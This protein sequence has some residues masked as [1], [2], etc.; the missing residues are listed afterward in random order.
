MHSTP[1]HNLTNKKVSAIAYPIIELLVL[2]AVVEVKH[3]TTLRI[4]AKQGL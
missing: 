4:E 1:N 3:A 2:A